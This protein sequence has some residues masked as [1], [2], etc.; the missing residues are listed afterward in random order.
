M[1][2]APATTLPAL[3]PAQSYVLGHRGRLPRTVRAV[4][5]TGYGTVHWP[6]LQ[7]PPRHAAGIAAYRATICRAR[8]TRVVLPGLAP[9]RRGAGATVYY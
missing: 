2:N 7:C 4:P 1:L 8:N 9:L 6:V 5:V 3:P